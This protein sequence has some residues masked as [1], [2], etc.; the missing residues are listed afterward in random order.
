[1]SG[2]V[3]ITWVTRYGSTA[4][5][6]HAIA[7]VLRSEGVRVDERPLDR[8]ENLDGVDALVLGCALYVGRLHRDARRFLKLHREALSH[9][10][11]ALFVLGP[12]D[13]DEKQWA[14]ARKQLDKELAKLPWFHPHVEAVFG[15]RWDP[16]RLGFPWKWTLR[17]VPASDARDWE[18]IRAWAVT[19]MPQLHSGAA[20]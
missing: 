5:V 6:A 3:M 10:P 13:K 9:M 14:A 15:G 20:Q 19:L 7:E 18:A 11:V 1:M 2:S 4:E 17:S 16:S 12:V 8:V